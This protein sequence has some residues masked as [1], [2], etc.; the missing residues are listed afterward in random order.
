M[1][2]S[3]GF[4]FGRTNAGSWV[5]LE[6]VQPHAGFRFKQTGPCPS[7]IV[8]QLES[9]LLANKITFEDGAIP[10]CQLVVFTN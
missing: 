4:F 6:P 3:K 8:A 10:A 9:D 7:D 2:T 5:V 1:A